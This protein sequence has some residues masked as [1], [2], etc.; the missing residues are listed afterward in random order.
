VRLTREDFDKAVFMRKCVVEIVSLKANEITTEGGIT[1][2]VP[3]SVEFEMEKDAYDKQLLAKI[4]KKIVSYP[5]EDE[6][7]KALRKEYIALR[8]SVNKRTEENKDTN[9]GYLARQATRKGIL[10]KKPLKNVLEEGNMFSCELDAEIGEEVYWDGF[11]TTQQIKHSLGDKTLDDSIIEVDDKLY[12]IIPSVALFAARRGE[13]WIP[14]NGYVIASPIKE[15]TEEVSQAGII[16]KK[17]PSNVARAR[18]VSV[19]KSKPVFRDEAFK[20]TEV[21][22]GDIVITRPFYQLELDKTYAS[23]TKLVR[24]LTGVIMATE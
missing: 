6:T 23:E 7:K 16:T 22:V 14:L 1:L 20:V 11:W 12:L 18:V 10:V 17:E 19:P 24:I 4:A 2:I 8:E 5:R 3:D 9:E 21:K 15:E 13:D